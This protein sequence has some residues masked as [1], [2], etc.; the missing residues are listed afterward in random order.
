MNPMYVVVLKDGRAEMLETTDPNGV[1]HPIL[2]SY[3]SI[4]RAR[5]RCEV[6]NDAEQ[7][8]LFQAG[9]LRV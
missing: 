8:S 3:A 5:R 7:R 1:E 6:E 9:K 2:D 4:D